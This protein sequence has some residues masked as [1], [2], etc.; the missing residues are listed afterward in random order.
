MT[1]DPATQAIS[2]FAGLLDLI[3]D[4]DR[5][6][7]DLLEFQRARDP[8]TG[9][10]GIPGIS[11][12]LLIGH[13]IRDYDPGLAY[14]VT[15]IPAKDVGG[16]ADYGYS[17][18]HLPLSFGATVVEGVPE[19]PVAAVPMPTVSAPPAGASFFAVGPGSV[20]AVTLQFIGLNDDDF[21]SNG[22]GGDFVD[23]A[24]LHAALDLIDTAADAFSGFDVPDMP[25]MSG[26]MS[27]TD[28][29]LTQFDA[30][31]ILTD[32]APPSIQIHVL[33]AEAA[34]G[35]IVNGVAV[36][37]VPVWTDLLPAYLRPEDDAETEG[38][39]ASGDETGGTVI[40][41]TSGMDGEAETTHP[42]AHDFSRD[43]PG[44]DDDP[45]PDAGHH[46]VTGANTAI[47]QVGVASQWIDAS[48]IVVGGDVAKVHA[49]SQVNVLVEHDSI[50]GQPVTQESTGVNIAQILRSPSPADSSGAGGD[51]SLPEDWNLFRIE[52][53]L[54]QVNWVKQVN[55]IT[56]FD[57][58]EVTFS[59][60]TTML[61]MGENE[62]VN[63]TVLNELGYRFDV[64]FV[65]GDMIDA[66][67]VSQ[68]NVLHDSDSVATLG[69]NTAGTDVSLADN[70]LFNQATIQ[71]HGI[72]S[73]AEM[74]D[75]FA[76][77][78]DDLA[79][80]RDTLASN[81]SHDPLM[82]GKDEV[83]ALQIDGDLIRINVFEQENIVG[84][85]DQML[86]D[87]ASLQADFQAEAALIAGSNALVNTATVTEYGIDSTIMAGGNV[88]DDALIHQAEWFDND[89]PADGVRMAELT[90]DAVAAFLNDEMARMD[91]AMEAIAPTADYDS[92]A[93][94]DVMQG[95]LA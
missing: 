79:A 29:V 15:P 27:F 52:A 55:Y 51:A 28:A 70:L 71:T 16:S 42:A 59:A 38:P 30:A 26:W 5:L 22:L 48:V 94:V 95:V 44:R 61:V 83:L 75:G 17:A 13:S 56:D 82:A 18:P 3:V 90:N 47:N 92:G 64:I 81:L 34:S 72:D 76:R 73:F 84:D 40:R 65:A 11:V 85:A 93:S 4:G 6:R 86:A 62:A 43:F 25:A 45:S 35:S 9:D 50:D 89:A 14:R 69:G 80:G 53:T 63:S 23:P 33:R 91:D 12:K 21:L 1:L 8:E 54:Y 31:S 49:I 41:T 20:V 39:D 74:T 10:E 36:D 67:I 19:T 7:Q 78:A 32:A 24:E 2:R 37:E 88:Y 66:T 77:A 57:R 60:Q 46:V 58:A 68:K 87:M